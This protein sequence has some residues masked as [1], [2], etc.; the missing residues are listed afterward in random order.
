MIDNRRLLNLMEG[1]AP[2]GNA[3]PRRGG[4]ACCGVV[5]NG[6]CDVSEPSAGGFK[7]AAGPPPNP[8]HACPSWPPCLESPME[9]LGGSTAKPPSDQSKPTAPNEAAPIS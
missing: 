5:S 7:L 4:H 9:P 3:L 6:C 1:R 2:L 8:P